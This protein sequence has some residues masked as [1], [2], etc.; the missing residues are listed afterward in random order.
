MT[1]NLTKRDNVSID[2]I[3]DIVN[4]TFAFGEDAALIEKFTVTDD[5]YVSLR[6]E[7]QEAL[8]QYVYTDGITYRGIPILT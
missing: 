8:P 2:T 5:Q 1:I 7:L 4:R 6:A 3:R